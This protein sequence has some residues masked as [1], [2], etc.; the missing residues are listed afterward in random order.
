MKARARQNEENDRLEL[1][2]QREKAAAM[3]RE[4]RQCN[5]YLQVLCGAAPSS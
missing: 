2:R 4:Q 5:E 1:Q 3:L